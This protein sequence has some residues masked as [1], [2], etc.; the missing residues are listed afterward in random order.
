MTPLQTAFFTYQG[1]LFRIAYLVIFIFHINLLIVI[2]RQVHVVWL[3]AA[4]TFIS[5]IG[6]AALMLETY[7]YRRSTPFE[8]EYLLGIPVIYFQIWTVIFI[9]FAAVG[10][11]YVRRYLKDHLSR[12]SIK[13]GI[14]NLPSGICLGTEDGNVLLGNASINELAKDISG[15]ILTDHVKFWESVPETALFME[16][17]AKEEK[18]LPER[19]KGK[20]WQICREQII[21]D[22]DCYIQ[23]AASDIS[24]QYELKKELEEKNDML[25]Q[26]KERMEEY[27]HNMDALV[28]AR[29]TLNARKVVHDEIG[30]VLLTSK[31]YLEHPGSVDTAELLNMLKQANRFLIRDIETGIYSYKDNVEEA[32]ASAQRI[33]VRLEINGDIPKEDRMRD[34]LAEHRAIYDAIREG[35]EQAAYE[36]VLTHMVNPLDFNLE[37]PS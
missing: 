4:E 12:Y 31:Y 10:Y 6:F 28:I 23:L 22:Q 26:L 25:N 27:S 8:Y 17:A 37:L 9:A 20:V 2:Y 21:S 29:E 34:A 24:R 18:I 3:K 36:A 16:S 7:I 19:K 32:E 1:E 35:D 15:S 5:L 13:E 11:M 30:H 33:G 14:D